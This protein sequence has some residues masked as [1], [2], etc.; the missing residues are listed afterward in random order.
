MSSPILVTGAAGR[1]GAVG[2]TGVLSRATGK[3]F[4]HILKPAGTP[5]YNALPV[6]KWMAMELGRPASK[7]RRPRLSPCRTGCRRRSLSSASIFARAMTTRGSWRR[8]TSA[9]FWICRRARST[10]APWS[11]SHAPSAHCPR[12]PGE[13]L[14]IIGKGAL[15]AWLIADEDMHLKN[16]AL[17]KTAEPGDRQFRTVRLA[18]LYDAVTTRVFPKLKHDICWGEFGSRNSTFA[19]FLGC[20]GCPAPRILRT[21]HNEEESWF[22]SHE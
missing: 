16:M 19:D 11:A 10:T 14:L 15:F 12:P 8:K 6:V 18:P 17:L 9:P 5:G 20:S 21:I 13:D 7:R 1:I 3:P 22:P 4:T 2:L